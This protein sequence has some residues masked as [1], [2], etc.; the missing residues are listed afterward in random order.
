[1]VS[2]ITKTFN[3][4]PV[5]SYL[6]GF[7]DGRDRAKVAQTTKRMHVALDI[8]DKLGEISSLER[9]GNLD[10]CHEYAR[11][12]YLK[13][14]VFAKLSDTSM[15]IADK[16]D[17]KAVDRDKFLNIGSKKERL[18]KK[19]KFVSG[20]YHFQSARFIKNHAIQR[21][22]T[23]NK[24]YAKSP[25]SLQH[26]RDRFVRI[27]HFAGEIQGLLYALER[28]R[29]L[30]VKANKFRPF[31]HSISKVDKAEKMLKKNLAYL[32][33][34]LQGISKGKS[35]ADPKSQGLCVGKTSIL[36]EA[37]HKN[38][39]CL[40][41][42]SMPVTEKTPN[43]IPRLQGIT[44]FS[45]CDL[46]G[47][48]LGSL[49]VSRCWSQNFD[50]RGH[51]SVGEAFF[52]VPLEKFWGKELESE[53]PDIKFFWNRRLLI[54]KISHK[55]MVSKDQDQPILRKLVQL[56]VELLLKE[57]EKMLVAD[58]TLEQPY[59]FV[60]GGFDCRNSEDHEE[61]LTKL[62]SATKQGLKFPDRK[63]NLIDYPVRSMLNRA[64]ALQT[65]VKL[66]KK[67]ETWD[68]IISKD[69]ILKIPGPILP[70]FGHINVFK[71]ERS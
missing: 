32:I 65:K 9:A 27:R 4:P 39:E 34:I 16:D 18:I 10:I 49:D 51:S 17:I 40:V 68:Q 67:T 64:N 62:E 1:M 54:E 15:L 55:L 29:E 58:S 41:F 70:R 61:I 7:L 46:S 31:H 42:A 69:S 28:D 8:A 37:T 2:P 11:T 25:K 26:M 6:T 35:I 48:V 57:R 22:K 5:L 33:E 20:Y 59:F 53:N 66:G 24:L 71:H 43:T 63:E 38:T 44:Q 36:D 14:E 56:S 23:A 60:A 50:K 13:R 45:I 30:L 21:I 12:Q 3:S 47:A 52:G 19:L